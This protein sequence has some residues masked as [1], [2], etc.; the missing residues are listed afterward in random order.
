L[1]GIEKEDLLQQKRSLKL[2]IN[3]TKDENTRLKTKMAVFQQEM[4]R[5]DKDIELLSIKL[6]Q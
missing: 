5:K 3:M 2:Q 1:N 4:D 6:H